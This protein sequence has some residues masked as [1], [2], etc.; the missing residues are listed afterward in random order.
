MRLLLF[1]T[2]L[3][4][5]VGVPLAVASPAP[6]PDDA[7]AWRDVDP[8]NLVLIETR[9]GRIAVELEPEFA[10]RPCRAHAGAGARAFL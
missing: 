7:K 5:A 3:A 1:A 6:K 10:P 2:L 9:Y 8:E 4:A